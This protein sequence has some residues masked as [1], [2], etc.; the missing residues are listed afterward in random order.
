MNYNKKIIT[1]EKILELNPCYSK[2]ELEIMKKE[3]NLSEKISVLELLKSNIS[4]EDILWVVLR[5]E[6]IKEK[7]LHELSVVFATRA[8]KRERNAG[9]DPHHDRWKAIEVKKRWIA[10][11]TTEP[12]YSAVEA[13]WSASVRAAYSSAW[14]ARTSSWSASKAKEAKAKEHK[15]QVKQILRLLKKE[16][17][18]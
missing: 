15:W 12:A 10:G 6:F 11:K 13:A 17:E 4:A 9:R 18:K 7:T 1:V 5:P 3:N 2:K 16:M 8:L 14:S